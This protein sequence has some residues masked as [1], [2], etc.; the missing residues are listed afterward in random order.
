MYVTIPKRNKLFLILTLIALR[1]GC[2]L[3]KTRSYRAGS[4]LA[5]L[6]EAEEVL[7]DSHS[8]PSSDVVAFLSVNY[9]R[10]ENLKSLGLPVNHAVTLQN[11]TYLKI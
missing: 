11:K 7:C 5:T 8:E 4:P 2:V 3:M 1:G 10:V 6:R 9:Q